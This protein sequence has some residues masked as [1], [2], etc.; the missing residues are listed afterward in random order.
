MN[1]YYLELVRQKPINYNGL[2]FYPI[3]FSY[4]C[5]EI[6]IDIFYNI[7]KPVLITKESCNL[8]DDANLFEDVILADKDLCYRFSILL[9]HFCKCNEVIKENKTLILCFNDRSQ[10]V[11]DRNNFEDIAYIIMKISGQKKIQVEKEPKKMSARQRDVWEKLQ[12]GRK[13]EAKKNEIHIYDILN[14]C[15]FCGGYHIP[16]ETMNNWT[17]WKI[18]NCYNIITEL[19]TYN[20]HL[21][22][23]LAVHDLKLV[24][25]KNHWI[26]KILVRD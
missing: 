15:E 11:I 18:M 4:I 20:D 23:G 26:K 25:D 2:L 3:T 7:L 16:Q 17:L 24:S 19:K 5:D 14:I 6:G 12:K 13:K 21:Q 10:F 9:I 1:D 22:I 8:L